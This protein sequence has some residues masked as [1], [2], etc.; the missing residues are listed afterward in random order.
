MASGPAV[1]ERWG[2]PAESLPPGHPAWDLEAR[3]LAS[4]FLPLVHVLATERIV[5]GGG[6]GMAPGLVELVRC[7]L[8]RRLAGY[9]PRL[10]AP[11]AM[12]AFI[13]PPAL[14][15]DAGLLGAAALASRR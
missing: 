7:H 15:A 9:A 6:L 12:E 10:D 13:V 1:G 14:G 11:G 3:Y 4:G 8:S 5:L 2:A